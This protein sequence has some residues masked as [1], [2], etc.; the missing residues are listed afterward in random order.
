[1]AF[2]MN[3]MRGI[4]AAAIILVCLG[5]FVSGAGGADDKRTL[6][7]VVHADLKIL[8]PVW[9]SAWI[10]LRYG[11]C[12]YDTLFALDS[13]YNPKPQMVDTY[14]ASADGKIYSFT[15][16]PGLKWHD[17]QPVRPEDCIA[18]LKRWMQR[19]PMGQKLGEF[20]QTLEPLDKLSFKLVL[21]EPYGIVL[22][23]LAAPSAA[24]FIMPERVAKTPANV[25]IKEH[26][27]S[28]P[29]RFKAEEWKPGHKT[30]F[31]RNKDY[32][33]RKEPAD[34]LSGGKVVKIDRLEWLY[35]PDNNTTLSALTAGEIDYF[36][37]PPL[38]YIQV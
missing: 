19:H 12:V 36:E 16:R 21:K 28:G 30:V 9:T 5:L 27:G 10:T 23:T 35:I 17:G 11:Y 7:A 33:P 32:I 26:I 18:S 22:R 20:V 2:R 37:T 14:K 34:L 29:F 6:K 38:E 25:Q 3:L 15:L 4:G 8:D 1:M 13:S 24:P 31:E